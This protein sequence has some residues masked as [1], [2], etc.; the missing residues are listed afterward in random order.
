[1]HCAVLVPYSDFGGRA[2]QITK[3]MQVSASDLKIFS[4]IVACVKSCI[5]SRG[6]QRRVASQLRQNELLK[7][8]GKGRMSQR[9]EEGK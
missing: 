8:V 2:R 3:Q 4:H 9:M 6:L 7:K 1:M 5:A